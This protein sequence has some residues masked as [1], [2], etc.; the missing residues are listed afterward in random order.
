MEKKVTL[1]LLLLSFSV[2]SFSQNFLIDVNPVFGKVIPHHSF[3]KNLETPI[4][5]IDFKFGV[6]TQEGDSWFAYYSFPQYGIGMTFYDFN[7]EVLGKA[8]SSYAYLMI[9]AYRSKTLITGVDL[10]FGFGYGF[11]IYDETKN[12]ENRMIS[13]KL[14]LNPN[15]KLFAKYHLFKKVMVTASYGVGHFSNGGKTIP[16][17]GLNFSSFT[18]GLSYYF[19]EDEIFEKSKYRNDKIRESK[20]DFVFSSD[21]INDFYYGGKFFGGQKAISFS[22]VF[23]K[24]I[25]NINSI[26]IGFDAFYNEKLANEYYANPI[27]SQKFQT[28]VFGSHFLN[29][30]NLSFLF[31]MGLYLNKIY[32]EQKFYYERVGWRYAIRKNILVNFTVKAERFEANFVE[33]GFGYRLNFD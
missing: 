12:P 23:S 6:Q 20:I 29:F 15:V 9:P 16:N 8:V 4:N 21:G 31:Q 24:D 32:S 17:Y 7:S 25:S 19:F 33:L 13:T 10:S 22:T 14:N 2:H 5:G 1:I 18:T 3:L 30:G 27:F 26:G 11:N 28:G